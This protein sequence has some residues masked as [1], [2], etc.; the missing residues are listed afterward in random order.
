MKINKKE[1]KFVYPLILFIP[2]VFTFVFIKDEGTGENEWI[3]WIVLTI[4]WIVAILL[5]TWAELDMKKR[6]RK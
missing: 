6:K 2:V 1:R 4:T 3:K 5:I